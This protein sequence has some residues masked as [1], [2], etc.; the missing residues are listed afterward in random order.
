MPFIFHDG[1]MEI[2][3]NNYQWVNYLLSEY[4]YGFEKDA[5]VHDLPDLEAAHQAP[6]QTQ[7]SLVL[8]SQNVREEYIA[9]NI[10]NMFNNIGIRHAEVHWGFIV[11]VRAR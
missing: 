5:L 3:K 4:K 7:H 2:N 6:Q 8:H 9:L 1:Y 10:L 11:L